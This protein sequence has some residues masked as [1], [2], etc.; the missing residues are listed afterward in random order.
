MEAD[1]DAM[2]RE[3]STDES[4]TAKLDSIMVCDI[5]SYSGGIMLYCACYLE[6]LLLT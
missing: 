2:A 1:T 5:Y 3:D 6:P 4:Y